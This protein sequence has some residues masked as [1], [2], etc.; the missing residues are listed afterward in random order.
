MLPIGVI[1]CLSIAGCHCHCFFLFLHKPS[2]LQSSVSSPLPYSYSLLCFLLFSPFLSR[3][4][5]L[6]CLKSMSLFLLASHY[7]TVF[8]CSPGLLLAPSQPTS[9]NWDPQAKSPTLGFSPLC[10]K[11]DFS[12]RYVSLVRTVE[13]CTTA[14]WKLERKTECLPNHSLADTQI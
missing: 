8:F 4:W 14:C 12:Y 11:R 7:F 6:C 1:P 2:V 3:S 13:L 5:V 10:A 9:D